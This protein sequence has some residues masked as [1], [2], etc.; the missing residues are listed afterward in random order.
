MRNLGT[1]YYYEG[2]YEQAQDLLTGALEIQRR[3][4][5]EEHPDVL[6]TMNGLGRVYDAAGEPA[7]AE[8]L[9]RKVME[10]GRRVLGEE[11]PD[12]LLAMHNLATLYRRQ[13]KDSEA[14]TLYLKVLE[15]RRRILGSAHPDTANTAIGL[16]LLWLEQ[17][18]Y[19]QAEP[20]LRDVI[21]TCEKMRP[22][23][24]SRFQSQSL[25]GASLAGQ[26]RYNDAESLLLSGYRG[27][28]EREKNIPAVERN[29]VAQAGE[30]V[31]QLYENWGRSEK[32]AE[33]RLRLRNPSQPPP[34]SSDSQL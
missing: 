31:V 14:E 6:Y 20:L 28:V 15:S 12:T 18:K 23:A 7:L 26:M 4:R 27:L 10:I 5:G 22:D 25:L 19:K 1:L 11:N 16:S 32:A 33:W 29:S 24:W 34:S 13:R 3:V 9:Y 2:R 17:K 8:G 30:R 21:S